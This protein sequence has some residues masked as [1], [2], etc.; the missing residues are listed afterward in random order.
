MGNENREIGTAGV[1]SDGGKLRATERSEEERLSGASA[2]V[3]E[4]IT[5]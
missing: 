4:G 5:R 2:S 1:E 3:R